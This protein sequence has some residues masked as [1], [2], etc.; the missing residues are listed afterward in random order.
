MVAAPVSPRTAGVWLRRW[1]AQQE[2]FAVLCDVVEHVLAEESE[3]VIVDLGRGPG[4]LAAR[5]R[6]RLPGARIIG[7]DTDPLL[8]GLAR[9]HYGDRVEW[10]DADLGAP[11]WRHQV[12]ATIHAAVS[13]TALHRLSP[14]RL[15][16]LYRVLGEL[17]TPGGVFVNGDHIGLGDERLDRLVTAIRERRAARAGVEH[18]EDWATWWEAARADPELATL[19]RAGAAQRGHDDTRL[20]V[21]EQTRLL[22]SAGF[23]RVTRSG[24]SVTITYRPRFAEGPAHPERNPRPPHAKPKPSKSAFPSVI[25][26][27]LAS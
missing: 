13:T 14:D 19:A 16:E 23:S 6:D 12:P 20:S 8:L 21:D 7:I 1:D 9:A 3:R 2:R 27:I 5:L 4:S 10:L 22:L 17:I 18:N 26:R 11:T 24:R 25:V 15:A